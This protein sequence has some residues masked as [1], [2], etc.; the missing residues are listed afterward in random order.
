MIEKTSRIPGFYKLDIEERLDRVSRFAD[1]SRDEKESF[2]K[3]GIENFHI[4]SLMKKGCQQEWLLE[5]C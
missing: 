1:L 5:K 4:L 2:L 3:D